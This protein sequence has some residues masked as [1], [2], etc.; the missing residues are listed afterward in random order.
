MKK[1][2]AMTKTAAEEAL[3]HIADSLESL[4]SAIEKDAAKPSVKT[5]SQQAEY[6]YGTVSGTAPSSLDEFTRFCLGS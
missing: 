5:A 1:T 6:T 4:A 2:K 3:L